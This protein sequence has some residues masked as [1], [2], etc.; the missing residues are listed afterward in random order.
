MAAK[1]ISF[2]VQDIDLTVHALSS[3]A[4]EGN[5]L[6]R[7]LLELRKTDQKAFIQALYEHGFLEVKG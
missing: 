3:V 5:E 6:A 7:E 4:I 2:T 1:T